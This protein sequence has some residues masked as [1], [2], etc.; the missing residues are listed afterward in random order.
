MQR[1]PAYQQD[2]EEEAEQ[3]VEQDLNTV[4]GDLIENIPFD[5]EGNEHLFT[6]IDTDSM[7]PKILGVPDK[8]AE[9]AK[10]AYA[11]MCPGTR[12][13]IPVRTPRSFGSDNAGI[14]KAELKEHKKDLKA[15][16]DKCAGILATQIPPGCN[17]ESTMI[18]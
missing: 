16:T 2:E 11:L 13:D 1:T 17:D 4:V 18:V 12:W 8:E 6:S 9:T 7:Y 10:A 3:M 5:V 15:Q 14:F